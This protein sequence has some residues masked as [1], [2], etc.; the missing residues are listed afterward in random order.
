MNPGGADGLF[1]ART[2][3]AIRGWQT[4]RSARPT[5]YLDGQGAEALRTAV[6]SGPAAQAAA[7]PYAVQPV[8]PTASAAQEN[9][10]W[11]SIMNST[12]PAEFEAYLE[13][14]P[15]GVFSAL[16]LARLAALRA[17]ANDSSAMAGNSVGGVG[18]PTIG[19]R[20][21]RSRVPGTATPALGRA[22]GGDARWRPGE[23]FRDCEA[24][25]EMVVLPGGRS[26]AGSLRGDG[27][28]V[29][30]VRV[31]D[32][33]QC[34]RRMSLYRWWRFVAGPRVSAVGSSSGGVRELE[35]RAGVRVV[36]EPDDGHD[37]SP[38]DRG[39][40]GPR[41]RGVA[42]R[43]LREPEGQLWN[44]PGSSVTRCQAI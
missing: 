4:S 41:C 5:E 37:V 15:N 42:A 1:G 3:A 38:A 19:S 10:F 40:M 7:S 23:V 36:A 12:N 25:P 21:S 32:G 31:G 6:A 44:L 43:M 14:F 29:S 11:Q 22:G 2:R 24:C 18:A 39:G 34:G 27:G 33:R 8:A 13:Q 35:R 20:A 26:G 9:L 30:S 28:R 16:S 17:P